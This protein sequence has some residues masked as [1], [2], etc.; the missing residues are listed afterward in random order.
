MAT[1]LIIPWS[2]E[3]EDYLHDESR[4]TG[5]AESIS[6]PT[7]EAEVIAVVNSIRGH[8]GRLTTQGARTGITAGA[9][10]NGGHILNLSRMNRIGEVDGG[11]MTVQP[12][13]LLQDIHRTAEAAGLL[14]PPDPTEATASIGGAVACNASGAM[15]HHY[16]PTRQWV[17]SLRLVLSDGSVLAVAR[18][19]QHAQGRAFSLTTES[20]RVISGALPTYTQPPVKS[21]AGYYVTD[22]MDLLDLFL[23]MEGTLGIV[24][25]AELILIAAPAAVLG[26]TA[27]LP[28][29]EAALRF[30]RALREGNG[31]APVA[32]EFF[33]HDAL[34]LLRW[35]GEEEPAFAHLPSLRPHFHTAVYTEFH[36]E[37][38]EA[39]EEALLRVADLVVEL[40]G[41]DDD[42]WGAA[43]PRELESLKA[44]RH[45][46]P[47]AVNSLI[48]RRKREAPELT[49][50][51]TDMSV[52][53]DR[54]EATMAMYR[55]GLAEAGLESVVFGHIGDSHVHV[56][57]LPRDM[58]DYERGKA[59]YLSWAEQVVAWGG[60]VSAEHGIGKLKTAF[61]Q[62]MY[63]DEG[64]AEMRAMKA[65]FDPG[66]MLN[67]GN[68][69]P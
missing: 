63:G 69:F 54:L 59:L 55:A 40:G 2:D 18:G 10:P 39:A 52:P 12:G 14:F 51:G 60:S 68:L 35:M 23:G 56:N 33:D 28:S 53:D 1:D 22:D 41:N 47:E 57:I 16:G 13:A 30:V 3:Y 20:G 19:A 38:D 6:F 45:A 42:T 17:R 11:T 44:F 5:H 32:I 21:A 61:L 9:V 48:G 66:G 29:E 36:C 64:I 8:G 50:L 58:G 27:F 34:D 65:A 62:L 24:T 46:V 26:M 43:T 49:K 31:M 67:P 37:E 25:E 15:S 4:S 7:S